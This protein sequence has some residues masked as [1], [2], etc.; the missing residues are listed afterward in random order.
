MAKFGA[1][2]PEAKQGL[3]SSAITYAMNSS[4]K[5]DG[6]IDF[7]AFQKALD[8]A[9]G[10]SGESVLSILKKQNIIDDSV[11]KTID[12]VLNAAQALSK[13]QT[14]S[15]A[16][17]PSLEDAN[18]LVDLIARVGGSSLARGAARVV[19]LSGSGAS[20]IQAQVGSQAGR[21]L[22]DRI[23]A[24]KVMSVLA[25]AMVDPKLMKMLLEKPE[26][27]KANIKLLKQLHGYLYAAGYL[28]LSDEE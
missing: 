22:L 14:G 23:P 28:A 26:S 4:F 7:A 24:A 10:D 17:V 19:G 15:A 2:T 13:S 11:V 8:G 3:A 27:T 16:V 21:K 9:I 25:D 20:L 6:S 1:R 18:M 5:K 12:D